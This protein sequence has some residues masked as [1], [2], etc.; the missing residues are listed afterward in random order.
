[1]AA[2]APLRTRRPRPGRSATILSA[3]RLASDPTSRRGRP[4]EID[5]ALFKNPFGASGANDDKAKVLWERAHKYFEGKLFN[6]AITDLQD[7]LQL[8][9]G[10]ATEAYELMQM[11][12]N[13]GQDE[14]SVSIGTALLNINPND[15]E[16][17]NRLGN[18]LRRLGDFNRAKN[19]YT[20]ALKV[21]ANF[22][23]A[24]Y[25]LAACSF[26]IATADADLMKQ[27]QVAEAFIKPRR[28]DFQGGRA[29][30]Y[31]LGNQESTSG[32]AKS[33]GPAVK[34]DGAIYTG[35]LGQDLQNQAKSWAAAYNYGLILDLTGKAD[36]A[37]TYLKQACTL[38]TSQAAPMNNLAVCLLEKKSQVEAAE[39]V[40][41]K[42]L[43]RNPYERTLVL[44]LAIVSKRANKA[45][46]TLKYYVYLGELLS[47]S[48]GEFDTE[49]IKAFAQDLY[50]RRKY[51]EA[52]PVF[53][54]MA[55]E[56]VDTDLLEK[57]AAM[58]LSQKRQDQY[59]LALTRL[60]KHDPNNRDA[61]QKISDAAKAY[62][63]EA[64]EK[65]AKGGKAQAAQ[66]I[67]KAVAIEETAERWV[68]LA[69][70][71]EDIGEEILAGNALQRWK[72]L[73][74]KP[75]TGSAPGKSP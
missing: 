36:D 57:L 32:D 33:A 49:K 34:P 1:L 70:L 20:Q 46:Q 17:L 74:V 38:D 56:H 23:F 73:T 64:Q 15:H 62:E 30:S 7:A 69:Q 35:M 51:V 19:V 63:T 47:R 65:L 39:A 59:L 13:Q 75:A 40:L 60:V 28:Y 8:N 22:A 25:N 54:T 68:E 50:E 72:E 44:N 16:L 10:Y 26:G 6:R 27:T 66:L 55:K 67:A 53:E 31:P 58:Y 18:S 71:Y 2:S 41:T 43:N 14:Q 48:M 11:L 45:F 42:A 29:G 3:T 4:R 21:K 37:I 5:V 52:I 12:S 61:A 9:P 24:R